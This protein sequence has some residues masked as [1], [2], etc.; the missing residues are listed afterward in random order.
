M[1][2]PLDIGFFVHLLLTLIFAG[3][4]LALAGLALLRFRTSA[5]GL[6]L[7]GAFLVWALQRVAVV[8]LGA[9]IPQ[10]LDDPSGFLVAQALVI[11]LLSLL[12]LLALGAGIA[13]LPRSLDRLS[14]RQE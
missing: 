1:S 13:L 11:H 6:L 4:M 12:E 5:T 2:A 3:T 8:I 7:S 10:L 9:F 14:Q